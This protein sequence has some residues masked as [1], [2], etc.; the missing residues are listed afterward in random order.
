[1]RYFEEESRQ[2]S[3]ALRLRICFD[4]GQSPEHSPLDFVLVIT[5]TSPTQS[6][7]SPLHPTWQTLSSQAPRHPPQK[8]NIPKIAAIFAKFATKKEGKK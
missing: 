4:L 3:P 8:Q 6:Y 2:L 5:A 7:V 1:M